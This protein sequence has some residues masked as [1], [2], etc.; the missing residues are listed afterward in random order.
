MGKLKDYY[1]HIVED[2]WNNNFD[3]CS[4]CRYFREGYDLV[5]MP[6]GEGNCRMPYHSCDV[7]DGGASIFECLGVIKHLEKPMN[8]ADEIILAVHNALAG[9]KRPEEI[10][11]IKEH[12]MFFS[13]ESN[14]PEIIL[15]YRGNTYALQIVRVPKEDLAEAKPGGTA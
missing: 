1:L 2:T 3:I 7:L 11:A 8:E 6:F 12:A 14:P 13:N 9:D 10:G 5:P 4:V 15:S